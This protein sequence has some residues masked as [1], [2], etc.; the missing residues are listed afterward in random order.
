MKWPDASEK[1]RRESCVNDFILMC[2]LVG[3]DFVPTIPTLAILEGGIDIMIDIY[4]TIGVHLTYKKQNLLY[5]HTDALK[6]FFEALS[7]REKDLLEDKQDIRE[8]FF[9]DKLLNKH[10]KRDMN[11]RSRIDLPN[12]KK[13]YYAEH[14]GDHSVE[15]V[16]HSYMEGLQWIINYYKIGIPDWKWQYPY[17]YAPF[18]GDLSTHTSTF[19]NSRFRKGDP[20]ELFMQLLCV[21]PP[22][23][24]ELLPKALQSIVE[25]N[26]YKQYYPTEVDVDVSGKRREWEGIV[27]LP[28]INYNHIHGEYTRRRET[29][30]IREQNR[31]K[32][33]NTFVYTYDSSNPYYFNSYYGK[34]PECHSHIRIITF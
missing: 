15:S 33:G 34:I 28:P 9:E 17:F 14:F 16:C 31:N 29:I 25:T 6:T 23:S 13:D 3:N 2:F 7:V 21:L 11:H 18:L 30:E 8:K 27:K 5:L 20:V 26:P 19:K 10:T 4:K 1:W 22:Q 32:F 12:Y 24:K